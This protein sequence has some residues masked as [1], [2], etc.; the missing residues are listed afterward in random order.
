MKKII[1]NAD[2]FGL[3]K[4]V[5]QAISSAFKLGL[6]SS[7]S[8]ITN[9]DGFDDALGIIYK[10]GLNGK[11]GIHLNLSEGKPL[12]K[13]ILICPRI[14]DHRGN[15]D[16]QRNSN[17]ILT[18]EEREA[19]FEELEFQLLKLIKSGIHPTHIDSHH[20]I[21][22]EWSI[23]SQVIKLARKHNI[24]SIRLSRNSGTGINII[25]KIYKFIFNTRLRFHGF[26]TT[27]YFGDFSD[28][29]NKKLSQNLEL[30]VHPLLEKNEIVDLDGTNL[31]DVIEK[32]LSL[33]N[34]HKISS[35]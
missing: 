34:S 21:H 19:I 1:I 25:K 30:M 27:D 13:K 14:V 3:S 28:L 9:M 29:M 10:N 26:W 11:V 23:G 22:T 35:Y 8:I 24:Q 20:H 32:I 18:K 31:V 7:S 17:F 4:D 5:N 15:L 2:D 33:Y 12:S 16:F 6:I